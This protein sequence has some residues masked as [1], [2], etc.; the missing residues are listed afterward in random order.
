MKSFSVPNKNT[1]SSGAGLTNGQEVDSFIHLEYIQYLADS[2]N[3]DG[4]AEVEAYHRALFMNQYGQELEHLKHKIQTH[5]ERLEYLQPR[6]AKLRDQVKDVDSLVP[7][8]HL[9]KPDVQPSQPW[10]MWDRFMFGLAGVGIFCLVIFGV[11]NI[12]FN[13]IES[14]IVSFAD[15]PYRAYF[16][17]ALLPVGAFAVKIGWDL[18]QPGSARLFYT[19]SC[20]VIGVIGVL[21]WVM[22]YAS[23]YPSLSMSSAEQ[24]ASIQLFDA[25]EGAGNIGDSMI[26]N[27]KWMDMVIVASQSLAE[28]FLSALLGI[29]MTTVYQRHRPVRLAINP[30]HQQRNEER[31]DFENALEAEQNQLAKSK[32]KEMKMESQLQVFLSY[33]R[34]LY[35]KELVIRQ[36]HSHRKH[37]M[38]SKI[39][40]DLRTRL[41]EVESETAPSNLLETNSK[42][43]EQIAARSE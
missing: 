43:P 6:L 2:R 22:T 36:R 3:G 5:E 33:A 40:S 19:W 25:N 38:L 30:L 20:L 32:G 34:T 1:S 16:W 35:E 31:E 42:A 28:I 11:L 26:G 29:F 4:T 14:G 17:A 13:L 10:N 27:V 18:I 24:L 12:S 23:M 15:Y 9:D 21:V 8:N 7:V 37:Q 41:E 39:A